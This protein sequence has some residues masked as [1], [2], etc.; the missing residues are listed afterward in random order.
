MT[1]T[2][3]GAGEAP[4]SSSS[5]VEHALRCRMC[6][7][8]DLQPTGTVSGFGFV[9]CAARAF[10]FAPVIRPETLETA[11]SSG[12]HSHLDGAP[13]TGW[14]D[15]SFLDPALQLVDTARGLDIL[16]FGTGQS[17]ATDILRSRG[18]KVTAVD[19]VPPARPHPDRLTGLLLDLKL[20]AGSF[21][22]AFA[23]QVFEHLPEPRPILDELLRLTRPGGIVLIHTDMEVPDREQG[24]ENWWYVTPLDHCSFFRHRTF[25]TV[26]RDTVH[27]VVWRD[28]KMIAI[29]AGATGA[30]DEPVIASGSTPKASPASR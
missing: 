20:P 22:L 4:A 13:Q 19:V 30:G 3:G 8:I 12:W 6:L 2:R 16:D 24:I 28:T 15:P 1:V 5:S 14:A 18:H 25:D 10:S 29:R 23:F 11:Y 27:H 7:G 26:F 9:T 17:L 21:D